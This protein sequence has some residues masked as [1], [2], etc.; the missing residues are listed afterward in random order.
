MARARGVTVCAASDA[1]SSR[2]REDLKI[3]WFLGMCEKGF[4]T[5]RGWV[6]ELFWRRLPRAEKHEFGR[7]HSAFSD[8]QRE[9]AVTIFRGEKRTDSATSQLRNPGITMSC[10]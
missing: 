9:T 4:Y 7:R 10:L 2:R 1:D 5:V 8:T 3:S 6:S